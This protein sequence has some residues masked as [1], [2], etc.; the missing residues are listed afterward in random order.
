MKHGIVARGYKFIK[1]CKIK[2]GWKDW[3]IIFF[4]MK[5]RTN[6]II[7]PSHVRSRGSVNFSDLELTYAEVTWV[8]QPPHAAGDRDLPRHVTMLHKTHLVKRS[9][10]APLQW[11]DDVNIYESSTHL[12]LNVQTVNSIDTF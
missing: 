12:T 5:I 2:M 10:T 6:Q 3:T 7:P 9:N 1:L 8:A 11:G 4:R